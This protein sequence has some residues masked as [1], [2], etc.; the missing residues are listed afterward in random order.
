MK[1]II[2]YLLTAVML[3][4]ALNIPVFAQEETAP[5]YPD[6]CITVP[7]DVQLYV[8]QKGSKHFVS[9]TQQEPMVTEESDGTTAYYFSLEDGKT[10]N[11]RISSENYITYAGKFKKTADFSLEITEDMLF[12]EEQSKT[13]IDRDVLSNSGYNVADIYMNINPQGHLKLNVDETYQLVTLRNWEA[14]DGVVSNYFIEPDYHYNVIDENGLVSENVVTVSDDGVISAI[15]EGVA[16]VLVTYDAINLDFG[17]G[18]NFYGAIWPENTGVFVVSVTGNADTLET[19]MTINESLND[20]SVKLSGDAIDAEHDCIYFTGDTGEYTFTSVS[21]GC[22]VFCAN[23]AVGNSISYSGF[24]EVTKND[25]NSFTVPLKEGRNIVKVTDGTAMEYQ[26]ITAKRVDITI[27]DANPVHVGDTVSVKFN[28]L[29][30]PANKLAG[31]YNMNALAMYRDVTGY[32]GKL[33][34]AQSAQ[35]NFAS[36]ADAQCVCAVLKEKNN[37]GSV[38][39]SKDVE[40]IVPE[41]FME[42][43]FT[44]SNGSLYVNGWGDPYGNH[45][46]ITLTEGK[47]PNL[48]AGAAKSA[49]LGK[50]PDVEIPIMKST[51]VVSSITVNAEN[52]KTDYLVGDKFDPTG[53]V[54]K[55]LYTDLETQEETEYTV[56]NYTV[57]PEI[58]TSDTENV[59][60]T[61]RGQSAQI[62]VNVTE[63]K[64]TALEITTMPSKT[65]YEYGEVFNPTGMVVTAVCENG[66]KQEITEYSYSPNRELQESDTQIT[67]T[68]TGD[69]G[70]AEE[71]ST[72][73]SVT[74]NAPQAS[75][76]TVSDTITVYFT[77]LGDSKHGEPTSATGT[78]TNKNKNLVTW[79]SRTAVT[80]KKGSCVLDAV[81]KA[82]S[83]AGIPYKNENN[84]ISEIKGLKEF[85]NGTL[86]GWM[87]TINGKYCELGVDEQE[88]KNGSDIVFHYTDDYTV[89]R[90]ANS[91]FSGGGTTVVSR[92]KKE[93]VKEENNKE[94]EEATDEPINENVEVQKFTDVSENDWFGSAVEEMSR[95]KI[96]QGV[97]ESEFSPHTTVTRAMLVTML[98]RMAQEPEAKTSPFADVVGGSYYENAVSWAH[99]NKIVNGVSET[100][101]APDVEISREQLAAIMYRYAQYTGD[102][103]ELSGEATGFEDAAEISDWAKT[104]VDWAQ[105]VGLINGVSKFE[106]APKNAATRAQTAV[107]FVRFLD[108]AEV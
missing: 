107:I 75:G 102:N 57:T 85:D 106:F 27:N 82:L 5:K 13:T 93:E 35:Y 8:G 10:Y 76:G 1:K 72:T 45:R 71:I 99:E 49:W 7:S 80:V 46:G 9:F 74:V 28:R 100:E 81:S 51:N 17:S 96:M 69:N 56:S 52:T 3:I 19:G 97:S 88:L 23:P 37:F 67:V 11:Y 54:V 68:Y 87:Y 77:L 38:S 30:H 42:E 108:M 59:T 91:G 39:Y 101:F 94:N 21:E 60:I 70:A 105:S 79:L 4:T 95:R 43:T 15:G 55:A 31:V 40:L 50:L 78:H 41:D 26:V 47:A 25:D 2:S 44:L 89:E 61:Y 62:P 104:A 20:S 86:S 84:Y 22:T 92:P 53:L 34:G 83:I 32:E 65:V 14:V 18:K 73:I 24:C 48:N 16:I 58:I 33:I 12:S 90:T 66:T 36:N 64:V 63:P 103:A 29:Y 6:A 98:Y